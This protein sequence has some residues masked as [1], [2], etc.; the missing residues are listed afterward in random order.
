[1]NSAGIIL[2]EGKEF[3]P[4][5]FRKVIDVN[6]VATHLVTLGL[7]SALAAAKGSVVNIASV[8]ELFRLAA[9]SR[10]RGKQGRGG[11]AYAF[12]CSGLCRGRHS[13]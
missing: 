9:Q 8:V 5:G 13:R 7:R 11:P 4:E 3:T 12:A 1:V 2:H 6:L 10:L